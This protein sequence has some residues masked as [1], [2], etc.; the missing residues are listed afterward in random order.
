MRERDVYIH[1]HILPTAIFLYF[2]GSFI[3]SFLCL[4]CL[5]LSISWSLL[6]LSLWVPRVQVGCVG[7]WSH[8]FPRAPLGSV[9]PPPGFQ[10]P[11]RLVTSLAAPGHHF[12]GT[13]EVDLPFP[14]VPFRSHHWLIASTVVPSTL[15]LSIPANPRSTWPKESLVRVLRSWV[16]KWEKGPKIPLNPAAIFLG[17]LPS[18]GEIPI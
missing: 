7:A 12:P 11:R 14:S 4:A 8:P 10:R 5:G 3:F 1:T 13:A 2:S 17:H 9:G 16:R 18:N 15:A 6:S